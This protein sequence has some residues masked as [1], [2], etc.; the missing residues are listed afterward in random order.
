M[1]DGNSPI[2]VKVLDVDYPV[3]GNLDAEYIKYLAAELD[4]RMRE[5]KNRLPSRSV[6]KTAVMTALNLEDELITSLKQ[7][8]MLVSAVE[9]KTRR[10]L[11]K[12]DE[13]LSQQD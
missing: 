10:M 9:E 2:F 12:L 3:K 4:R 1:A 7:K 6:E 8:H 5:M 11:N 13:A